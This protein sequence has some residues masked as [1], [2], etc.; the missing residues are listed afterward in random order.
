[1]CMKMAR[2]VG[3]GEPR[4]QLIGFLGERIGIKCGHLARS[5][6]SL[7]DPITTNDVNPISI[8]PSLAIV[9]YPKI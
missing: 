4:D 2:G 1:M 5:G 3:Q 8:P 6:A 7:I 9:M